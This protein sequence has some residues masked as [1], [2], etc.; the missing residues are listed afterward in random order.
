MEEIRGRA[1]TW[2]YEIVKFDTGEIV[3]VLSR[4]F[5]EEFSENLHGS[6]YLDCLGGFNYLGEFKEF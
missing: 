6:Y 3:K 4:K 1:M 2:V 5:I